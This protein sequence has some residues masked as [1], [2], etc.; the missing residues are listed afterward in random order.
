MISFLQKMF[1]RLLQS[2]DIYP[3]KYY[4]KHHRFHKRW[5]ITAVK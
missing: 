1:S 2:P 4:K 5:Q 3:I